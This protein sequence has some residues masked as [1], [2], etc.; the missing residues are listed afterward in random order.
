MIICEQ[1]CPGFKKQDDKAQSNKS[2]QWSIKAK[3]EIGEEDHLE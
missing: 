3:E 1:P 2:C